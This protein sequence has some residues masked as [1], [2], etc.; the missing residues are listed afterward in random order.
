MNLI[1]CGRPFKFIIY[2]TQYTWIHTMWYYSTECHVSLCAWGFIG[3]NRLF[4]LLCGYYYFFILSFGLWCHS[5]FETSTTL[6][7]CVQILRNRFYIPA[8]YTVTNCM[9]NEK[10]ST[11]A[12]CWKHTFEVQIMTLRGFNS[13]FTK[14]FSR[15][16]L[17]SPRLFLP[18]LSK[19]SFA[20]TLWDSPCQNFVRL[21]VPKLCETHHAKT[22]Y[23]FIFRNSRLLIRPKLSTP[24][25]AKL[26]ETHCAETLHVFIFRDSRQLIVPKL[27]TPL[28]AKTLWDSSCWNSLGLFRR[29]QDVPKPSRLQRVVSAVL[30]FSERPQVL[31]FSETPIQSSGTLR[32]PSS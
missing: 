30:K 24:L 14:V 9:N 27:S 21:T 11:L 16:E 22:L 6:W 5:M 2:R 17:N 18:K 12:L 15:T 29:W 31:V 1:T 4:F 28:F 23:A 19:S 32:G 10:F 8:G 7:S 3:Y 26:C 20:K 25:F 13:S